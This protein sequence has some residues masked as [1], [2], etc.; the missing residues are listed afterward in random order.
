MP[1]KNRK[2][3]NCAIAA[4][5]IVTV[6]VTVTPAVGPASA[7]MRPLTVLLT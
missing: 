5:D 6:I 1:L 3:P 4:L 7:H 2:T